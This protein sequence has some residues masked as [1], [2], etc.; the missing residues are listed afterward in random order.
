MSHVSIA[1]LTVAALLLH[2]LPATAG[3]IDLDLS[4]ALDR[5]H[6]AAPDA[7]SARGQ[8]AI[9]QAA[10]TGA[11]IT[12][13]D[14]LELEGGGG[15]R[16]AA[17]RAI[18]IDLR[19][20]QNLEPWRRGPR[21]A[22][23]RTG[24]AQTKAE[25]DATLRLLDIE[26]ASAFYETLH[27]EL[28]AELSRRA[29]DFAQMALQ[30]AERRRKAGD[31][32]DLDLNLARSTLGRARSATQATSADRANAIGRLAALIGAAQD[33]VIVLRGDLKPAAVPEIAALRASLANRPDVR[34]LDAERI[35]ASA[36][37]DQAHAN[38]R[39]QLA[40]WGDY[41]REAADSIITGGLR[42]TLPVWNRAQGDKA[43]AAA[44]ERRAIDTR[45][46]VLRVA[47][48]QLVDA[49]AAY[50]SAAAAVDVFE[51]DV[52]PVLND[53]EHLLQKTIDAG[54]IAV[55]DYLVA[56]QEI[57]TGRREHLDRLLALAKAAAGVRFVAGA[58]L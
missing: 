48:R 20:E 19:I 6:R 16:L 32:T 47:A 41:R 49:L 3:Q 38:G 10:V 40:L 7:V 36:E 33:D 12:F 17:S 1:R 56:R 9:A 8:I 4:A 57:L 23:A 44:K 21:R 43:A 51:R 2:A 37:R 30:A 22:V 42:F 11:N 27:A 24:V 39:M 5:A 31:I 14:N 53:S 34:V 15:P 46:A 25:V 26:V 29:E 50:T 28:A 58:A 54:Q 45:D 55:S 18:D 13:I 35:V 52:V